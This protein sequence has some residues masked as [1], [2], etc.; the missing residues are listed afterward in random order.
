M[1]QNIYS[2]G[3]NQIIRSLLRSSAKNKTFAIHSLPLR[4]IIKLKQQNNMEAYIV[5]GYRTAVGKAPKG[6]LRFTPSG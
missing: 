3:L 1:I 6:S 2:I 5:T 4:G